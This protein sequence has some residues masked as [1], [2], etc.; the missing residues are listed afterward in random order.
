MIYYIEYEN[1]IFKLE[2]SNLQFTLYDYNDNVIISEI[3]KYKTDIIDSVV[4]YIQ[5]YNIDEYKYI[6][7]EIVRK[8][9]E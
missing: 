9:G 7:D 8:L 4:K 1:Q 5:E 2:I 3:C 6:V